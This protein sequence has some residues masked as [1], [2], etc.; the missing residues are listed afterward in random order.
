MDFS[1]I[2]LSN[3]FSNPFVC[4]ASPAS[5]D[6]EFHS[7]IIQYVKNTFFCVFCT[8]CLILFWQ[9]FVLAFRETTNNCLPFPTSAAIQDFICI[10]SECFI[11]LP[12][13]RTPSSWLT[14]LVSVLTPFLSLVNPFWG[15]LPR[16]PPEQGRPCRTV[17]SL[18]RG[19]AGCTERLPRRAA[20]GES[21]L[22][23]GYRR[24]TKLDTCL[25]KGPVSADK[26]H[27]KRG[28]IRSERVHPPRPSGTWVCSTQSR[29]WAAAGRWGWAPGGERRWAPSEEQ[30][31]CTGCVQWE[32]GAQ[33]RA[34][35]QLERE[36]RPQPLPLVSGAGVSQRHHHTL[37]KTGCQTE[38]EVISSRWWQEAAGLWWEATSPCS[39]AVLAPLA[40]CPLALPWPRR[41][42]AVPAC[43]KLQMQKL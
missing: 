32:R 30:E 37:D 38:T 7:L 42:L 10:F 28:E 21:L 40:G 8:Y 1:S 6:N 41:A 16:V 12:L 29:S 25:I 5:R 14:I 35:S 24:V 18:C 39:P 27:P 31:L 43:K 20:P 26:Q 2:N 15:R 17:P 9:P 23:P 19:W 4:L 3:C 13:T 11:H 36:A 33:Q 22:L 34:R